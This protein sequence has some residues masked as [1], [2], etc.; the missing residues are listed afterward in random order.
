MSI[1]FAAVAHDALEAALLQPPPP[2][3]DS[4]ALP[5]PPQPATSA[6]VTSAATQIKLF[7]K[8]SQPFF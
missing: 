5:S 7:M 6:L 3:G 4:P 2:N 1:E 8:T